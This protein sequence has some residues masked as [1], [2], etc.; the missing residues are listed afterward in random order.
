MT[1]S[2]LSTGGAWESAP[3][4][5]CGSSLPTTIQDTTPTGGHFHNI[6]LTGSMELNYLL[7]KI[8]FTEK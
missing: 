8:N 5:D 4:L 1:A 3:A 2:G 7:I 6:G